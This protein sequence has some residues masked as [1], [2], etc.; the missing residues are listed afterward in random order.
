MLA[1]SQIALL[2]ARVVRRLHIVFVT[3]GAKNGVVYALKLCMLP[4]LERRHCVVV[5]GAGGGFVH[6]RC[7]VRVFWVVVMLAK[8]WKEKRSVD[9]C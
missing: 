4:V 6:V 5:T 1:R 7:L 3:F 2:F 8:A 9:E